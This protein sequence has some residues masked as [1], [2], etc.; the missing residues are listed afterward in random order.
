[1]ELHVYV[2]KKEQGQSEEMRSVLSK[3]GC[4]IY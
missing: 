4:E 2:D 1:M 3:E